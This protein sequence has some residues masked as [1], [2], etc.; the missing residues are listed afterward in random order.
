MHRSALSSRTVPAFVVL[1]VA[2]VAALSAQ[3][4]K[5]E[6]DSNPKKEEPG[7]LPPIGPKELPRATRAR[8]DP[9]RVQYLRDSVFV[10]VVERV[11]PDKGGPYTPEVHLLENYLKEYFRRSGHPVASSA[12]AAVYRVECDFH[13]RFHST[14]KILGRVSAWKYTGSATL[15]VLDRHGVELELHQVPELSQENVKSDESAVLNLRRHMAKILWDKIVA[16]G[17]VFASPAVLALL[18]SLAS[19]PEGAEALSTEEIVEKLA[20]VGFP[21]VPYLLEAL[22]DNRIVRLSSAYPGLK[23]RSLDDLRVF[24]IA[25]K[26]LE[27]IFQKVSRMSLDIGPEDPQSQRLRW[28]IIKGWENEWRRFC[29]PFAESPQAAPARSR[30]AD[31]AKPAPAAPGTQQPPSDKSAPQGAGAA[32]GGE[33]SD[34]RP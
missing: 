1:A 33:G 14:L 31:G 11:Q 17:K 2:A 9:A 21:A 7:P 30:G 32:P 3:D 34:N 12:E 19:Q 4:A 25:D 16:T 8:P 6:G 28:V 10:A 15:R 27:E 23:G 18:S 24:H 5:V 26:S 13:A 22:T 20:D 29:K